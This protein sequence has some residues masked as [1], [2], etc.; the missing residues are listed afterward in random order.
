MG[1]SARPGFDGSRSGGPLTL[2]DELYFGV[3]A[4]A[5]AVAIDAAF[6]ICGVALLLF[7]G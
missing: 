1:A 5:F 7:C 4:F 3:F 6:P 2:T